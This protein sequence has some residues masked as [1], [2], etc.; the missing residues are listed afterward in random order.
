MS[1]IDPA[2]SQTFKIVKFDYG[3]A[4]L[5]LFYLFIRSLTL[6]QFMQSFK[7]QILMTIVGALA[8]GKAMENSG[9]VAMLRDERVDDLR[10]MYDLFTRVP[11]TLEAYAQRVVRVE[12]LAHAR[13]ACTRRRVATQRDVYA[14]PPRS[15]LR[16]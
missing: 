1:S 2:I 5:V 12:A 8:M 15:C 4:L 11:P 10:R 3:G 6:D 13:Y 16:P 7:V 14:A 9:V